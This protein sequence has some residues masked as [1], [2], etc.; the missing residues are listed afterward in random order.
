MSLVGIA[1]SGSCRQQLAEREWD[2]REGGTCGTAGGPSESTHLQPAG[3]HWPAWRE[4]LVP[5]SSKVIITVQLRYNF[6]VMR[7]NTVCT[8]YSFNLNLES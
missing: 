4:A 2:R 8:G 1:G 3:R 7:S 5:F 6:V